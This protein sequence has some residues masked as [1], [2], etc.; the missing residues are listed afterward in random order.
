MPVP[1]YLARVLRATELPP[2]RAELP[3][4]QTAEIATFFRSERAWTGPVPKSF[5]SVPNKPTLEFGGHPTWAEFVLLR[6]LESDDWQGVWVKNWGGRAFWR[7]VREPVE[8]PAAA[9]ALFR[10]IELRT[11]GHGG[12]CWDILAWR[13]DDALFIESKQRGRDR[14]RSTQQA[15]LESALAEGVTLSSFAIAEWELDDEKSERPAHP[16]AAHIANE[17][18]RPRPWPS[19]STRQ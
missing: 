5:G 17:P 2:T 11:A 8:L 16:S 13:G 19:A 18:P 6:L 12:G 3:T 10:R 1:G 14:L 15:W 7:D 4:G 9:N